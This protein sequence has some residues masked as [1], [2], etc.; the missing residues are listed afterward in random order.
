[1]SSSRVIN[2]RADHT[3]TL[4]AAG[5]AIIF[6]G[7]VVCLF[8]LKPQERFHSGGDHGVA[9]FRNGGHYSDSRKAV[10]SPVHTVHNPNEGKLST[11]ALVT[12]IILVLALIIKFKNGK[13]A[14]GE[15]AST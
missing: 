1:M 3:P 10:F 9:S 4:I 2:Q 12:V 11:D 5:A 15:D 14:K 8:V 7:L 13:D 6:G